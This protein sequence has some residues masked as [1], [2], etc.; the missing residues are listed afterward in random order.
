MDDAMEYE[1]VYSGVQE[2]TLRVQYREYGK[3]MQSGM[4]ARAPFFQEL[5]Y[6]LSQSKD[7]AFKDL[8]IRVN[9]AG[10]SE[11]SFVVLKGPEALPTQANSWRNV[12]NTPAPRTFDN[13]FWGRAN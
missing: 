5:T 11:I 13:V 1:L 7:I 8:R 3:T 9:S 2:R 4:L 10:P 6:D 12:T